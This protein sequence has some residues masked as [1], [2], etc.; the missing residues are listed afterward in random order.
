MIVVKKRTSDTTAM[1]DIGVCLARNGIRNRTMRS[2]VISKIMNW[3]G[4]SE[5]VTNE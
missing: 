2:D 1:I 3:V 5:Q 4:G